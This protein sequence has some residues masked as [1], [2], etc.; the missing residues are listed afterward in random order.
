MG[1]TIGAVGGV[2]ALDQLV[3][4]NKLNLVLFTGLFQLQLLI[5]SL[6]IF[7]LNFSAGKA[8]AGA[9]APLDKYVSPAV[10]DTMLKDPTKL[11]LGGEKRMLSIL[12]SDIRGFA[13]SQRSSTS[14]PSRSCSTST[15]AR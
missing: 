15:W 12:F 13:R 4:F 8:S 2:F 1:L 10:I 6:R 9:S 11:R 3:F 5:Q 7:L 14:G